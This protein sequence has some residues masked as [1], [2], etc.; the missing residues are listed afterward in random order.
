[1]QIV[2]AV[3]F[4]IEVTQKEFY[5]HSKKELQTLYRYLSLLVKEVHVMNA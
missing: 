4:M 5:D 1:M 3:I 2:S